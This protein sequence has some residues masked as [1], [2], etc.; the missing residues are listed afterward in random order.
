VIRRT[1]VAV[2]PS[3]L[4]LGV[5]AFVLVQAG[6]WVGDDSTRARLAVLPEVEEAHVIAARASLLKV[7]TASPQALGQLRGSGAGLCRWLQPKLV[8][9]RQVGAGAF[10][11]ARAL[12]AQP[13]RRGA[14]RAVQGR[15]AVVNRVSQCLP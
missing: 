6:A 7:R 12:V 8:A 4:G 15:V 9:E 3:A 2:D 14:G 11:S 10:V 1:T 5:L 13:V